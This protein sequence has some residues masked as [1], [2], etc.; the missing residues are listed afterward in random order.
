M[1]IR[2]VVLDDD[3]FLAD[4]ISRMLE[5]DGMSVTKFLDAEEALKALNSQTFDLLVSDVRLNHG[6]AFDPIATKGG[7][8]TG[9]VLAQYA[10][11]INPD[12]C[13]VL[14]SGDDVPQAT[15]WCSHT[16]GL[17]LLKRA[18]SRDQFV[19]TVGIL[20]ADARIMRINRVEKVLFNF[21]R[22]AS[23]L[24]QRYA[25]RPP[26]EV[27]DEYD[28]QDLLTALFCTHFKDV[29]REEPL[30]SVAGSSSRIDILLPE[31]RIAIETKIVFRKSR[32]KKVLDEIVM[33]K[34]RYEALPVYDTVIF[35]LYDPGRL[36]SM[37][38]SLK[39]DIETYGG[40]A[41]AYKLRIIQ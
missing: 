23:V 34:T 26:F 28:L 20:T 25:G 31:V 37:P 29:R 17:F 24:R 1:K 2:A 3:A 6:S 8:E 41:K 19:S 40:S 13:V 9:L 10:K 18:I 32:L 39:A 22:A 5:S 21:G 11:R 7:H 36:I 16:G 30:M 14:C 12:I 15:E 38:E 27:N 33:D 4:T 35:V